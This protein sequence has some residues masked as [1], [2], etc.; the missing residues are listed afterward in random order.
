MSNRSPV[1]R[2]ADVSFPVPPESPDRVAATDH[3]ARPS[4]SSSDASSTSSN[5]T[6]LSRPKRALYR[7]KPQVSSPRIPSASA[8]NSNA[9]LPNFSRPSAPQMPP[10]NPLAHKALP[11]PPPQ[12]LQKHRPR[13]HS[14]GFFEPSLPTASLSE[15]TP[16]TMTNLS[17][18]QIAAQAA[19]QHQASSHHLR[20]RSQ[21]SKV[22]QDNVAK[23]GSKD[24]SHQV[25]PGHQQYSN[26]VVGGRV[27]AAKTAANVAFPRTPGFAPSST[28]VDHESGHK[29]KGE[30]SKMK[31]FSKPKHIG[32]SRDKDGDKHKSTPS[33]NNHLPLP[34]PSGLS[35]MVNASTT[36]L[37]ESS[38][39]A[40]SS[41]Y[42]LANSSATTVVLA[43]RPATGEREKDREKDKTHKHH[44]LS[45][46]KLKLK[47]KDDH[48]NLPLS[49]ASSN[50]K[51]LDPS[52]PQ[53]LYSFTPQSPSTASFA[54]SK[55]GLDLR[56][57]GR[58]LREK[59]KEE[60]ASAAAAHDI[61]HRDMDDRVTN[62]AVGASSSSVHSG[63]ISLGNTAP[64]VYGGESSLKETLQ[65]FG[66]HNM[67]PEDAWDFLKAKLLVLF[68]GEDVR[69]ALE[70]LNKLVSIHIQ[71][72]V[73]KHIPSVIVE[74]LRD[75]LQTGFSS[76]SHSLHSVPDERVVPHLVQ[77][78][79]LVFGGV[80]PF[81][82][83]V[84][85]P[86]DLEFKGRGSIMTSREAKEFWGALPNGEASNR[87]MG[88][89]LDVRTIVLISFRDNVILP[90][91]EILKATFSRL[92]LESIHVNVSAL[93]TTPNSRP[94][95]AS[96]LDS[97]FGSYNSQSSTLLNTTAGSFS[98]DSIA[99][100][101][102]RSRAA[103]NTSN[104]EYVTPSSFT[105]MSP[106][107]NSILNPTLQAFPS[108]TTSNSAD[109][110]HLITETVGRMLQCI[111]VLASVQTE[112]DAQKKIETLSKALKHN[113][114]GRGRTGRDR[115]GFVGT[116]IR[117]VVPRKDSDDTSTSFTPTDN[118]SDDGGKL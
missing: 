13:Q 102:S 45:R 3:S 83:A 59:K 95:T 34:G 24:H 107:Q 118:E 37:N 2:S 73:R 8:N 50:S 17:A 82:Q 96:A 52:A 94:S 26:G 33:P 63:P 43:D 31:I 72:C 110:S 12:E 54:K 69:I 97:G 49:S 112:D 113:W 40:S 116:K 103:S 5:V 58:A 6:S 44:F 28:N 88:D 25:S 61:G 67:A 51:P 35:R 30:K 115:R 9:S 101:M 10:N 84:F 90:R 22:P 47:D 80:L 36:S 92:S 66:L 20:N 117:P 106:P 91:Y 81:I 65:G 53:S 99:A 55:S 87:S 18:S 23:K 104:P 29:Q 56:H 48:F 89:E 93:S 38:T 19:M 71:R 75:L 85:L 98:S 7:V 42:N 41:M 39:S 74:D 64:S 27:L 1:L 76:L 15:Q 68:E 11:L 79:L 100:S 105:S 4:S 77:M 108:R 21:P 114:L 57:G 46:Q 86:L 109:T 62:G 111:S 70:D 16:V 14:Q 60:K 78:W 32:L